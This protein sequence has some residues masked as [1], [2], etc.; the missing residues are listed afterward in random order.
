MP[1]HLGLPWKRHAAEPKLEP[2]VLLLRLLLLRL[3]KGCHTGRGRHSSVHIASCPKAFGSWYTGPLRGPIA[4][5]WQGVANTL[6][7]GRHGKLLEEVQSSGKK[8]RG[9]KEK[10][11]ANEKEILGFIAYLLY[12]R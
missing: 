8:G 9:A 2:V 3:L 11:D 10:W 7:R 5:L 4:E 12:T 1:P 6:P